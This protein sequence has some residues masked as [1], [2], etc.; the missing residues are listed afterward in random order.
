MCVCSGDIAVPQ[1]PAPHPLLECCIKFLCSGTLFGAHG[2]LFLFL[3]IPFIREVDGPSL[4]FFIPP[5]YFLVYF[6]RLMGRFFRLGYERK[7]EW[8]WRSP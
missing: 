2:V 1:V 8:D 3:Y 6:I 4:I 7:V 5:H